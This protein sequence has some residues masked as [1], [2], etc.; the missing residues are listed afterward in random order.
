VQSLVSTQSEVEL[1]FLVSAEARA[2]ISA[3]M[4]RGS[5][6]R[7]RQTLAA[8]Y[9][10]T[11]D[12]RLARA[13]MAWRLRREGGRWIQTLKAR[14]SS[15]LERFEHE[16]LRT[17]PS[18]DAA[19]H[20]GTAPGEKLI[21]ILR[22]AR[23]DGLEVG[24]RFETKVRRTARRVRT[25]GAVV[26]IAFDE[27]R[28]LSGQSSMR[29]REIEFEL[30]SGS[31]TAMLG[32]AERWRKRFDLVYDPRSKAERGNRLADG[33]AFPP[34]RKANLPEYANEAHAVAAFCAVAD[35]CLAHISRNAI[36]LAAGDSSLRVEHVHQLR[37][38]IRRLRSALRSFDDWVPP[39]PEPLV[40]GLREL[41]ATLGLSRDSDVLDS[42]V[43]AELSK[44]GAPPLAM[45]AGK[46]G[47]D[48]AEA[49]RA[50]KVQRLLLAWLAWRTAL[51]EGL[52]DA[53]ESAARD[54]VVVENQAGN[55]G[56]LPAPAVLLEEPRES[57]QPGEPPSGTQPIV[58]TR[59]GAA[60][61]PDTT[62]QSSGMESAGSDETPPD[63]RQ[64][65]GRAQGDPQNEASAF[66]KGVERRLRRWHRRIVADWKVF[67]EL[68]ETSLHSLRKRIKRQRYAVEFFTPLLRGRKVKRYLRPLTSIQDRMGELND[69]FVAK[70]LYQNLV[71]SDPAAW[72]ALGWLTAR[73]AEVRALAKPELKQL[74][75]ADP[76]VR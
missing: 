11:E 20:A 29:V 39:P 10:D 28:L 66:H 67:D 69:L 18:H 12:R 74:A 51:A 14:G 59:D 6:S 35:E 64:A 5:A 62:T 40:D 2:A 9:L 48:P 7:E 26:E 37:V 3:E 41:F 25:R 43:V 72:F 73:I 23:E 4:A 38:G 45:P 19:A 61:L 76:P 36:G 56:A 8:I 71:A 42:G 68:D 49:V 30:I 60:T 34:L 24:V 75:K 47:P 32:L 16:V 53:R 27:G 44:V 46:P 54:L 21:K 52:V 50:S 58:V 65:S 63:T 22:D 13:G 33:L 1:K 31:A 70:T 17:G 57:K 55:G 15:A